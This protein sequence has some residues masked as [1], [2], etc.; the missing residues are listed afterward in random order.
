MDSALSESDSSSPSTI[1]I[2]DL[3]QQS[4]KQK[5]NLF[6]L[7]QKRFGKD[8]KEVAALQKKM[9][10]PQA[11]DKFTDKF[12]RISNVIKI[13]A[14]KSRML[15]IKN[16]LDERGSISAVDVIKR[17]N[18]KTT[19]SQL[20]DLK[21]LESGKLLKNNRELEKTLKIGGVIF[22]YEVEKQIIDDIKIGNVLITKGSQKITEP[23]LVAISEKFNIDLQD[24]MD[25]DSGKKSLLIADG[26]VFRHSPVVSSFKNKIKSDVKFIDFDRPALSLSSKIN[27]YKKYKKDDDRFLRSRIIELFRQQLSNIFSFPEQKEISTAKLEKLVDDKKISVRKI[28]LDWSGASLPEKMKI[29]INFYL[30]FSEKKGIMFVHELVDALQRKGPYKEMERQLI[31]ELND[32]DLDQNVYTF[33]QKFIHQDKITNFAEFAKEHNVDPSYYFKNDMSTNLYNALSEI[34]SDLDP[35][36]LFKEDIQLDQVHWADIDDYS[37]SSSVIPEEEP[38]RFDVQDQLNVQI[39]NLSD[40]LYFASTK[41]MYI[42]DMATILAIISHPVAKTIREKLVLQEIKIDELGSYTFQE[43]LPELYLND[44]VSKSDI[45]RWLENERNK[46]ANKFVWKTKFKTTDQTKKMTAKRKVN[47]PITL[48]DIHGKAKVQSTP[49]KKEF[50]WEEYALDPKK[51]CMIE[52]S[53]YVMTADGLQ[54]LTKDEIADRID[55]LEIY[56]RRDLRDLL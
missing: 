42:T 1:I 51:V 39:K 32:Y 35:S 34:I 7:T 44:A 37:S 46:I 53:L 8:Q 54:C 40:S 55:E 20:K 6:T 2:E 47:V 28:K 29:L 3:V 50:D 49:T 19:P 22:I 24:L 16:F 45:N 23:T 41:D 56:N 36:S 27:P 38:L 11:T 33:H 48:L 52:T 5:D 9:L 30:P 43:L 17:L 31:Q 13:Q 4:K 12:L 21:K 25:V 10:D 14:K 26:F 15:V 18:I